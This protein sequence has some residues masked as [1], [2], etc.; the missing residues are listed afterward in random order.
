[1]HIRIESEDH[2]PVHIQLK[3]QLKFLILNGDLAPGTKL[4][5]VRQLAGFLRI[6][7]NTA[8]KAYQELVQEGLVDCRQGRGCVVVDRP[9]DVAHPLSAELLAMIDSAIEQ[10]SEWGITPADF[11]TLVYARARQRRDVQV[12]RRLAFVECEAP[13]A[14]ALAQAIQERLGVEV[15]PLVLRDLRQPTAETNEQLRGADI[16]ATTFFH[17]QEVKRL[18]AKAKKEVVAV[19]VKPHL[20]KLIQI[21]GIP[22][23]T[24]TALVCCSEACAQDMKHSLETAG[25]KGLDTLLGGVDDPDKLTE[26]LPAFPVV[27]AS[28]YVAAQVRPLL[29]PHQKLITLDYTMLDEGAVNWLRHLVVEEPLIA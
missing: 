8:L 2:L 21:A 1:M 3:E 25:I 5:T 12:K 16:V 19:A 27:I 29:Q 10:A 4:P 23:G 20:E 15:M 28:D 11:S 26:M 22:R 17:I 7:R 14:T 9:A 18:F 24:P 13:I 6:N